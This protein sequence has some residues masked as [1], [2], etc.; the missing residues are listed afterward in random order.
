M[1]NNKEQAYYLT[2]IVLIIDQIIKN[3]VKTKLFLNQE[4]K[5][6]NNFFS[7][8]YLKNTGAAFS[9]LNN[10]IFILIIIS[11]IIIFFLDR[12]LSTEKNLNKTT[13][14]SIGLILGGT[15]GNLI[16]RIIHKGV[17][18]YLSFKIFS[19]DF[20]VFN[21]A[22]ITITT[23]TFILLFS[24]IKEEIKNKKKDEKKSHA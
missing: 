21:F 12:F 6:I 1:K 17:I 11:I 2:C 14:T 15:F 3:I 8:L 7:I 18:D 5:I 13:I 23:G 19:Y 9:I 10:Q 16:D 20:P 22:D 24:I 4:I